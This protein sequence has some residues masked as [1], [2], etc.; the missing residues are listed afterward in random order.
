MQKSFSGSLKIAAI[1]LA[2]TD[3]PFL[4]AEYGTSSRMS[5][6]LTAFDSA[7]FVIVTDIPSGGHPEGAIFD[8]E[9]FNLRIRAR[10][11]DEKVKGLARQVEELSVKL[12]G[13]VRLALRVIS[14]CKQ[15]LGNIENDVM[16]PSNKALISVAINSLC[17]N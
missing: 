11:C 2:D 3:C 5:P 13:R 12:Q 10:Q 8:I 15:I 7:F 16:R 6:P 17:L 4:P 14:A 9:V 1:Y